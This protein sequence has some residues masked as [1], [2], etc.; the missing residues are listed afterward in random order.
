MGRWKCRSSQGGTQEVTTAPLGGFPS[1]APAHT[2]Y[3]T[4]GCGKGAG[5]SEVFE[6]KLLI[7]SVFTQISVAGLS[8]LSYFRPQEMIN[9]L[10]WS[11]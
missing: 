8:R 3:P 9:R 1:S 6:G 10:R 7:E 4:Y 2:V 11:C 5:A